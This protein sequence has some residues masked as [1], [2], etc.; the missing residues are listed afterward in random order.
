MIIVT[1]TRHTH[2]EHYPSMGGVG[3]FSYQPETSIVEWSDGTRLT[4]EDNRATACYR[5]ECYPLPQLDTSIHAEIVSRWQRAISIRLQGDVAP[6][7]RLQ[8][9]ARGGID[10]GEIAARVQAWNRRLE[11]DRTA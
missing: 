11:A 3:G 8:D 6:S 5:G 10:R 9:R 1:N 7:A 4:V 2:V